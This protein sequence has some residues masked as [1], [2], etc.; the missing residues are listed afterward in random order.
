MAA[1]SRK[2][3]A[4]F[5]FKPFSPKQMKVLTWW[6]D[7]SPYRD[8]DMMI[9][10]GAVRSGKTVPT[11]DSFITWS[12][13][14]HRNQAF[15]L[16]SK[17]MGALK[18]NI[19]RPLFQILSAKRI[20][21]RYNRSEHFI[22]IGS[23]VYYCFGANNEASQ[24]VLQGLTAAGALLDEVVLFPE[25]FVEQAI[26]RCSVDGAKVFCTCNP[27]GPYHWFKTKYVDQRK[28]KR[29]LYLHFTMDDN[30]T[31]SEKVKERYKRLFS[32][33]FYKRYVLGLW[34]QAEGAIYDMFDESVHVVDGLPE[35]RPARVYLVGGD[36]G[37]SNPTCFLLIAEVDGALYVIDEYWYSL[38]DK[39]R[40]KT[41]VD[42]S[43]DLRAFIG[44][45]APLMYI[46]PEAASFVAQIKRDNVPNIKSV[47]KSVLDGIRTVGSAFSNKKLFILR[48]KAP[49]LLRE[50]V[51]YVWDPKAQKV[52]EDKPLKENDHAVDA[53]RYA[54][55]NYLRK[56]NA[57][58]VPKHA[59]W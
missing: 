20:P 33:L 47:D 43:A 48:G 26:A 9:A 19:L 21:Y 27:E 1:P 34:V 40:Q 38:K 42:Y 8:F 5:E 59:A 3:V 24:D 56:N 15:I 16:A 44:K 17:S 51:G 31:L 14:A 46:D 57:G 13:H 32:G 36:Y 6:T 52:G 7:N 39:G 2:F 25:S 37:T 55:F 4:P 41:D 29:I 49:N 12:L 11:I 58:P 30:W 22:E 50:L 18:R 23:N 28:E 10:D 53:L 54:V 35:G 45:R